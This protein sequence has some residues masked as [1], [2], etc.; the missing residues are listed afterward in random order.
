M[1]RPIDEMTSLHVKHKEERCENVANYHCQRSP[2]A[3]RDCGNTQRDEDWQKENSYVAQ[4]D[5]V[6][7]P[8]IKKAPRD[9]CE[10]ECTGKDRQPAKKAMKD[11]TMKST[12]KGARSNACG[13]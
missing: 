12:K 4:F 11:P 13:S 7:Y 6:S 9:Y 8:E 10:N 2:P 5:L 3:H 1:R